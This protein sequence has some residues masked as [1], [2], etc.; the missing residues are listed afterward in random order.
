MTSEKDMQTPNRA[1]KQWVWI[2]LMVNIVFIL[3]LM[4][5]GIIALRVGNSLPEGTDILFIVGKNPSVEFEDSGGEWKAGRTT[6]IFQAEYKDGEGKSSVISQDGTKLIAPGVQ[7]SYKFTMQNSGN[8]AV[9]YQTDLEFVLKIGGE[10]QENYEFPLKTKLLNDRG[11]YVIG[12]ET[13]WVD[14][15]DA[16]L[17]SYPA[18]LGANSYETFEFILCWEF[19]GGNDELDTLY[20]DLSAE[21]GVTLTLQIKTYAEEAPDPTAQGGNRIEV[22]GTPEYGGT[23][24]WLWVTL[25]MINTAIL[26]FYIAWLMNKRTGEWKN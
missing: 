26:V 3:L 21:K 19:E 20:G 6:D 17:Y 13:E 24:R 1:R 23:I 12:S 5:L 4:T 14:V 7:T 16:A 22:E 8:M 18:L 10:I 2:M 9:V 11:E 25:L 15:Q